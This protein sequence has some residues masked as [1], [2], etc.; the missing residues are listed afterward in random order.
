MHRIRAEIVRDSWLSNKFSF[1]RRSLLHL[2]T[3]AAGRFCC[4]STSWTTDAHTLSI[5]LKWYFSRRRAQERDSSKA[6]NQNQ[7]SIRGSTQSAKGVL[8][9][10]CNKIGT[11]PTDSGTAQLRQLLRV[12]RTRSG[13]DGDAKY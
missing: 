3:S 13:R 4:K 10:F 12:L 1:C 8:D 2:L 5:H 9:D 6:A 7:D 11:G